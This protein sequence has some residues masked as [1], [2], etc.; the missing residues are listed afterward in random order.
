MRDKGKVYLVGAGPGDPGLITVKGLECLASADV[1]VY[2]H[3]IDQGLLSRAKEGAEII[4]AGKKAGAYTLPQEEINATLLNKAS[5]GKVVVRLKGGDPFILGRGGEEAEALAANNIPFEVVPG[6]TAA[7]AAPAYAG[8]PLTHRRLSSSFAVATG[9]EQSSTISK[10][11]ADTLVF[12]MGVANLTSI[13]STLIQGGLSPATSAALIQW[14]T[15]P[16]Q[17]VVQA[18]L[19]NIALIAQEKNISPPAVL[20]VGKVVELSH[21]LSWFESKPLFGKRVVVTR[22]ESRSRKL[23]R[24]LELEGTWPIGVPAINIEPAP[25][26]QLQDVISRFPDF[27]WLILTSVNG[28]QAL[29]D[30]LYRNG[31]DARKFSN[32][33][34]CAI[35]SATAESLRQHGL[36][37]D[38]VPSEYTSQGI[39]DS[40][41][42][43]GIGGQRVLLLRSQL[44]NPDL[45]QGLLTLGAKVE[46]VAI[47]RVLP[48][49]TT[50]EKT[51]RLLAQEKIDVITF[52]SPSTVKG[53]LALVGGDVASLSKVQIACL[54]PVTASYAHKVGLKVDVVA[55]KHTME[56][57]V[58]ALV[59]RYGRKG[60]LS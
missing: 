42:E 34:I 44:A 40:F 11:T 13:T 5:Q 43:R 45:P 28:V 58:K 2:D 4:Y 41:R 16:R 59:E 9:H 27:N 32:L 18:T 29:F 12:L 56:G 39:L 20:V 6:I 46:E 24:L 55:K 49:S 10:L 14:G 19:G 36:I 54:G 8:I 60:G 47:Y 48:A 15:T 31:M 21:K 52:T 23:Q 57:L 3:L 53:F 51:R 25:D 37:A 35:G 50:D 17:K 1:I 30:Y 7:V 33:S 26:Q 38:L 22:E